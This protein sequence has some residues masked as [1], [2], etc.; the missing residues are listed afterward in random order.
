MGGL[1]KACNSGKTL[2]VEVKVKRKGRSTNANAYCWALCTDIAK[3]LNSSKEEV[4]QQAIRSIGAFTPIP[5]K[6]EAVERYIEIWKAHGIGWVIEDMGDS[7]LPGYKVL[8]CY[9]GSSTYDTKEM[10]ELIEWLTQEAHNLGI[11]II[12]EADRALLVED[13]KVKE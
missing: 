1:Q 2:T 9:H 7:K 11:D 5:I 4:Y 6:A 13:W 3:E 12:S 8:A 10:S